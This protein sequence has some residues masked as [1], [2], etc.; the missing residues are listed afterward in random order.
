MND[1]MKIELEALRTEAAYYQ[2]RMELGVLE[3][4]KLLIGDAQDHLADITSRIRALITPTDNEENVCEHGD[5]PA[6]PGKRF[7]S[8]TCQRCEEQSTSEGGCDGICCTLTEEASKPIKRGHYYTVIDGSTGAFDSWYDKREDAEQEAR[9]RSS[10][11]LLDL[12]ELLP[13]DVVLSG[14]QVKGIL[15]AI[16]AL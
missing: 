13:G 16:K 12:V 5:H 3:A 8:E 2:A 15:Q 7:C 4:D 10:L 6:P 9:S 14:E 11:M 1:Q